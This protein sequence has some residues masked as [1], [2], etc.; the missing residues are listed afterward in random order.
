MSLTLRP[1]T[2]A[3]LP[4]YLK[5]LPLLGVDDAP[6]DA[7]RWA[8][9]LMPGTLVAERDGVGVGTC[10][11]D[12]LDGSGYV[13]QL[14]VDPAAQRLGVGRTLL[15]HV[16]ARLLAAGSRE[17]RLNVKPDNAAAIAL[18]ESLG[19]RRQYASVALRLD[20]ARV[21]DLPPGPAGQARLLTP[22]E[23][24]A[25]ERLFSLP[26]GQIAGFRANQRVLVT[27][28][29]EARGPRALAAFNPDYPGAFPFR[30]DE[31]TRAK[32]LLEAMHPHARPGATF[33]GV[34]VENDD[35]LV[36]LLRTGGASVRMNFDHYAGP[37]T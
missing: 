5:L 29:D 20:W 34:V 16:R 12:L 31:P 13:R 7:V 22:A 11:W 23:D 4:L 24:A 32:A 27:L 15:E 9:S 25:V 14:I 17:W 19:F 2:P 33:V 26:A 28:V 3:D 18:Y 1:A 21:P 37:L 35:A 6:P 8:Q 10:T 30:V 36:S